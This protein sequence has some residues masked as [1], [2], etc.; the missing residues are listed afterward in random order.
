LVS[1]RLGV[2]AGTIHR[3]TSALRRTLCW[4]SRTKR[5]L[6]EPSTHPCTTSTLRRTLQTDTE[7]P[8]A[9][10]SFEQTISLPSSSHDL[11]RKRMTSFRHVRASRRD[12]VQLPAPKSFRPASDPRPR[13]SEPFTSPLRAPPL[14][15]RAE[16]MTAGSDSSSV[17]PR[18]I[19][20]DRNRQAHRAPRLTAG[21][22][23][24]SEERFNGL[25]ARLDTHTNRQAPRWKP[26]LLRGATLTS[27]GSPSG[28]VRALGT[29]HARSRAHG[30]LIYNERKIYTSGSRA[31]RR[32]F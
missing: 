18:L 23:P 22:P 21:S 9:R 5:P 15:R 16:K 1:P 20:V 25:L 14:L 4:S 11:I 7:S 28:S 2:D 6:H 32:T 8:M 26:P 31:P 24:H 19:I 12:V 27:T 10:L 17:R 3:T 29:I 30:D 13:S